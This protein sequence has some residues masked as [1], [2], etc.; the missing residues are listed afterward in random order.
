MNRMTHITDELTSHAARVQ[1]IAVFLTRKEWEE[2]AHTDLTNHRYRY[3]WLPPVLTNHRFVVYYCPEIIQEQSDFLA[4][5]LDDF[6]IIIRYC[7]SLHI[8]HHKMPLAERERYIDNIL[9]DVAPA[10]MRLLSLV[11]VKAFDNGS[12]P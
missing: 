3:G 10:S 9:Y 12:Q 7:V 2:K 11:Q 6:L 8:T 4:D 5:Q 1:A